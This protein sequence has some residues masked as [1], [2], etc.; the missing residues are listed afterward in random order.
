MGLALRCSD[1]V[2]MALGAEPIAATR[3][4]TPTSRY[5]CRGC[6]RRART[7]FPCRERQHPRQP[8]YLLAILHFCRAQQ[9]ARVAP[10]K[11][12]PRTRINSGSVAPVA[13][14]GQYRGKMGVNI[15]STHPQIRSACNPYGC[16]PRSEC[17]WDEISNSFKIFDKLYDE[18][19]LPR[20][21]SHQGEVSTRQSAP[22]RSHVEEF[23]RTGRLKYQVNV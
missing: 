9:T 2:R 23:V 10:L 16:D 1:N 6:S 13:P 14:L 21:Y 18:R 5:P 11:S 20:S 15:A 7:A 3:R 22:S 19:G 8:A 4:E 12:R 17:L